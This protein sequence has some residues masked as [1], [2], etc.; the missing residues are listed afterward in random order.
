MK[1]TKKK[2]S[3]DKLLDVTFE[4]VYRVG[5]CGAGTLSIYWSF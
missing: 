3:R 4:E 5:Y 1:E 2:T